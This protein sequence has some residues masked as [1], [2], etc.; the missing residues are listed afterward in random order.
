MPRASEHRDRA[1]GEEPRTLLIEEL[2]P[3][4]AGL[5]APRDEADLLTYGPS[6]VLVASDG[7]GI[8][9]AIRYAL[10]TDPRR[11]HGLI[12]DLQ[13]A[14][15]AR[16]CGV[17]ERL[18]AAAEK[19]LL[20][21]GVRKINAVILDGQGWAPHF[22]RLG[23]WASRKT[24]VMRWGLRTLD[25]PPDHPDCTIELVER[26]EIEVVTDLVLASYQ[27]YW[28]W[29]REDREDR[30]W[31][32]VDWP[33]ENPP[34]DDAALAA[35][36]RER[37]RERVRRLAE[38]PHCVAFLA[39]SGNRLVGMCD[40]CSRSES[41]QLDFGVLVLRDFGGKQLGSALLGRALHWLHDHGLASAQ[42]T[43]TSGLDDYD[44]TV[45]LYNLSYGARIVAEYVVL[46]KRLFAEP[47]DHPPS[48]R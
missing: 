46:V 20:L 36:M 37:V 38:D 14:P 22:Y 48:S 43:T 40:A 29:W 17:E 16:D 21:A 44:P 42:V 47:S 41:D 39:Y 18:I 1:P 30:R 28:R 32:R 11:R 6:T 31:E 35:D 19:N 7:N 8:L 45:Y 24:V 2:H 33:A 23:Y 3:L 4:P 26:P 10:R 15:D 13:I 12:A 34:L 25:A 5:Q 27:P 9:G